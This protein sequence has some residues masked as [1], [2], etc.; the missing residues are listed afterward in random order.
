MFV[1][2]AIVTMLAIINANLVLFDPAR[3]WVSLDEFETTR[4]WHA[5]PADGAGHRCTEALI[6]G[7]HPKRFFLYIYPGPDFR[8]D[9]VQLGYFTWDCNWQF[10]RME[11]GRT[12][13]YEWRYTVGDWDDIIPPGQTFYLRVWC[14]QKEKEGWIR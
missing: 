10:E 6:P 1:Q 8:V 4:I 7:E 14:V 11:G 3:D 5:Y 2:P 12:G 13:K 9:Q